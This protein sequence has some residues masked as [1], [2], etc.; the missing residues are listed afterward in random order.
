MTLGELIPSLRPALRS[1]LAAEV[2][3]DGTTLDGDG[4]LHV[5]GTAMTTVAARFGTPAYVLDEAAFR[6]RCQ[7]YRAALPGVEVCYAGKALLTRAV[8][9]WVAQEG[10]S[11]DVCSAGEL[12]VA[13][14]V[15]FPADRIVLHGNAK[16]TEDLKAALDYQ[17]GR[18][19]IDSVDEITQLGPLAHD[20]RV[21]LRV[22][23]D[24]DGHTHQAISTG[25]Q[26]QKFGIP[27][28][29]AADAVGQVLGQPG[30]RLV[31][32]HCHIGSQLTR[33][34]AIE[35]ATRRLIGL[36]GTLRDQHGVVL[37]QLNIGGGHAV[38]YLPGDDGFDLAGLAQRLTGAL[39]Y[40]CD[41]HRLP[42]PRLT[43]EPGRALVAQAGITLYR[44]ITVKHV[45]GVRTFV[46][47]DGGMS[48]NPRPA[49]YGARYTLQLIGRRSLAASRL[50]TVVGRHCEAGDILARDVP[51]PADIQ[52][53][54]LLAVATTGAYH[55]S[56]ASTYNMV[57]RPPLVAVHEGEARLLIRRETEEDLL[58]RDVGV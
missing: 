42:V 21:L 54:D 47:V 7:R 24:V 1:K 55:H 34:G 29:A 11:L 58:T 38:R 14:S 48:D 52:A 56:L 22:T 32:L 4:E 13:R 25:V 17:V 15:H 5:A 31:G 3:P 23:P 18:I 50:V 10:L 44:V 53:G 45:P 57:G 40:E 41:R 36:L 16:T 26:D 2:W 37:P 35:E 27:L 43:V 12:A 39:A 28:S 51:L 9:H 46:A 30:L 20:Q 49:L 8:A 19:V 33:I 6:R